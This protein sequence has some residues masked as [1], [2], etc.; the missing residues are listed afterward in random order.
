VK[1]FFVQQAL[2][3]KQNKKQKTNSRS[4]LNF[5]LD[6]VKHFFET[7]CLSKHTVV[8]CSY[9]YSFVIKQPFSPRGGTWSVAGMIEWGG[10]NEKPK[11]SLGLPTK[12]QKIPGPK[13]SPQKNPCQIS[14]H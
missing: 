6:P 12:P 9:V 5:C 4:E 11:K 1:L 13:S 10:K 7:L 14:K 3:K 8:H 2:C